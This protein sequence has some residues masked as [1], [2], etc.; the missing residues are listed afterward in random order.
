[1]NKAKHAICDMYKYSVCCHSII[2]SVT[3]IKY[4]ISYLEIL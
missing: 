1:M 2:N 4:I 3:E